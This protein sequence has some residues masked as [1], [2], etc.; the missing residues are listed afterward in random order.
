MLYSE[1]N[2]LAETQF[3][4]HLS[5]NCHG[6][7]SED[8]HTFLILFVLGKRTRHITSCPI[9]Q[10]MMNSQN[11]E[12]QSTTKTRQGKTP[13]TYCIPHPVRDDIQNI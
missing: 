1:R 13:T 8:T 10:T 9:G 6:L 5:S 7:E 3:N 4:K 2:I 11:R 12:W